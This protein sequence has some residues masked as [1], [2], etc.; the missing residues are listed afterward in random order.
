M[1]TANH[2][3]LDDELTRLR[4]QRTEAQR[5]SRAL[6]LEVARDVPEA[7]TKLAESL[8]HE[9]ELQSAIAEL[10][11]QKQQRLAASN[12][13][14][15]D[16]VLRSQSL[17]EQLL[18]ELAATTHEIR[19][20]VRAGELVNVEDAAK[21]T[22]RFLAA[23][24]VPAGGLPASFPTGIVTPPQAPL[25]LL[26][27]VPSTPQNT[28]VATYMRRTG[29]AGAAAVTQPGQVKPQ[30][31]ITYEA[32]RGRPGRQRL[33]RPH[34]RGCAGDGTA[35]RPELPAGVRTCARQAPG[36]QHRP[37]KRDDTAGGHRG[38]GHPAAPAGAHVS[39]R[40]RCEP[41]SRPARLRVRRCARG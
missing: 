4:R 5:E 16:L 11:S 25:T 1:T 9:S 19:N 7:A 34:R 2:D 23:T 20:Y 32:N 41:P 36:A 33:D 13:A 26:D 29:G 27:V 31:N 8:N 40:S 10:D 35:T 17:D 18:G 15:A 24:T 12:G 14:G 38:R 3:R 21:L 6:R 39:G 28:R 22:G 37:G 30:S